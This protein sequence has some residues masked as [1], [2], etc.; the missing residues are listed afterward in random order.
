[1]TKTKAPSSVRVLLR[2]PIFRRLW[3]AIAISSFGD[4]LGLLATTALAAYLTQH[5][6]GLAQ[7]AAVSGVLLT[8]LLPDLL[9]GPVA[10]A[11]VDKVDRRKV[12]VIGDTLAGLLY[13]SIVFGGNLT[14]LLISQ[15]LVEAIGLFTNPSKQAIF[16]NIVPRERL[17]VANQLNYV[18]PLLPCCPPLPSSSGPRGTELPEHR[19]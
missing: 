9:L 19:R 16:V 17:A 6:S 7:G 18:S 15:F 10:G 1:M 14:W 11:L 5:S 3:G 8:R 4:W 2:I 12:A 13:L